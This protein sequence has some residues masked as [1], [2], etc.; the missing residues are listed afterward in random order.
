M[1]D[2]TEEMV[3]NYLTSGK[4]IVPNTD[5][6]K[7]SDI[8]SKYKESFMPKT[9]A[10]EKAPIEEK[11]NL[12]GLHQGIKD[13]VERTYANRTLLEQQ[14]VNAAKENG[15]V[16]P[17]QIAE[18]PEANPVQIGSN[19]PQAVVPQAQTQAKPPE[20]PTLNYQS[21]FPNDPLGE[22]IAKRNELR[23]R[24]T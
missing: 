14:E 7:P 24:Q 3:I 17:E 5:N 8:N 9:T 11:N 15:E 12:A 23:N 16:I 21:I 2:V 6:V 4:M 13:G 18:A 19:E 1:P 22:M 10:F 20:I